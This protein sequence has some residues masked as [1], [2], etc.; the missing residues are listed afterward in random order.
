MR[1]E[2]PRC[3]DA[4]NLAEARDVARESMDSI[5]ECGQQ[6]PIGIEFPFEAQNNDL[7]RLLQ[8]FVIVCE[9]SMLHFDD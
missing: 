3:G 2:V 6:Y 5:W 1:F 9:V 7:N 8:Q 4:C